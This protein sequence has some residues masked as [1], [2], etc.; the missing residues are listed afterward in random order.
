MR[1]EHLAFAATGDPGWPPYT[2]HERTTRVYDA[3]S[4]VAP[5]PEERARRIWRDRRFDVLDLTA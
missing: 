2:T 4:T 5:Y 1:D 3:R